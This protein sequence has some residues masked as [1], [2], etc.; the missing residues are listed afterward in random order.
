MPNS[1]FLVQNERFAFDELVQSS[2]LPSFVSD[3]TIRLNGKPENRI[4]VP[5]LDQE[6]TATYFAVCYKSNRTKF[7]CLF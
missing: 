3:L 4:I 5:I 1:R 7:N 6:A 2:I